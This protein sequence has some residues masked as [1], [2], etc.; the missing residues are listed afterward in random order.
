MDPNVPRFLS[1]RQRL[2]TDCGD[3]IIDGDWLSVGFLGI[4][5]N[6][7]EQDFGAPGR[8]HNHRTTH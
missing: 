4:A 1:E 8:T 2:L 5:A 3:L 6:A 7:S